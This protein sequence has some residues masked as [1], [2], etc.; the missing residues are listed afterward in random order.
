MNQ[1]VLNGDDAFCRSVG[2]MTKKKKYYF[3]FGNRVDFQLQ[4]ISEENGCSTC[5]LQTA[6]Q[7]KV[8]TIPVVG[9][10]QRNNVLAAITTVS[11]LG[12][13]FAEVCD[14]AE[15]LTLPEGRMEP[16]MNDR[17]LAIF[18]DYAHTA[19]ALRSVLQVVR[20]QAQNKVIVVFSCGGERDQQKE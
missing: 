6:E 7:E 8:V 16:I 5:C 18:I 14:A 11:S 15:T 1:L 2:V 4:L 12:F 10:Y 3:G 17:G 9:D 19:E 20:K 13:P